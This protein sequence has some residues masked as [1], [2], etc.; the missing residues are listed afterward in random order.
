MTQ[1]FRKTELCVELLL[2][3]LSQTTKRDRLLL[4]RYPRRS[5][6]FIFEGRREGRAF[7]QSE[8]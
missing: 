7:W 8:K 6:D 1:A 2:Y 3:A 4:N 5:Q